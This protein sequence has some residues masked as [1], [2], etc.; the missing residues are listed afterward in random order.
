M[1][2]DYIYLQVPIIKVTDKKTFIRVDIS[3]NIPNAVASAELI[4][5]SFLWFCVVKKLS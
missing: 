4:M 2:F 3:F 1:F 5:V